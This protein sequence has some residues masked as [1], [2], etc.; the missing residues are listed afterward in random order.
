MGGARR[1]RILAASAVLVVLPACGPSDTPP[2][3]PGPIASSGTDPHAQTQAEMEKASLDF[4]HVV[5]VRLRAD[6]ERLE[7][8]SIMPS[9]VA[10]AEVS[11]QHAKTIFR[12]NDTT[13]GLVL[14]SRDLFNGKSYRTEITFSD[15]ESRKGFTFPVVQA[16]GSLQEKQFTLERIVSPD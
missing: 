15:L 2:P 7:V 1:V 12:V 11:G 6:G 13:D 9:V 3:P 14:F 10:E 8:A 4:S 5:I 16:D